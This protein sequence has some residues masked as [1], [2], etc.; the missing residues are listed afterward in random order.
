[1]KDWSCMQGSLSCDYLF[2]SNLNI[3]I[4]LYG[5]EPVMMNNTVAGLHVSES[6]GDVAQ[7]QELY[8]TLSTQI[9][10]SIFRLYITRARRVMKAISYY[11]EDWFLISDVNAWDA[12][13]VGRM[14]TNKDFMSTSFHSWTW[15]GYT[16]GPPVG[17]LIHTCSDFQ[18]SKLP[19]SK[20]S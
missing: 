5:N 6:I 3:S 19:I 16:D 11:D 17:I 2:N 13:S 1:M 8:I 9:N 15:V 7:Q 20:L 12:V 14:C 4:Q 18:E 10:Q